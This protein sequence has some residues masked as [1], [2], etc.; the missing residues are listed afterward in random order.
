MAPPAAAG[1]VASDA[2][3]Q[4][5]ASLNSAKG[6]GA[7]PV[8][9]L[10]IVAPQNDL[11]PPGGALAGAI[12]GAVVAR[13]MGEAAPRSAEDV[14]GRINAFRRSASFDLV[15]LSLCQR[16]P[17]SG[18][19]WPEHCIEGT[20]GADVAQGNLRATAQLPPR[21]ERS[22]GEVEVA[23]PS[24][25][26]FAHTRRCFRAV[27]Q[28]LRA[29]CVTHVW[30]CGLAPDGAVAAAALHAAEAGYAARILADC[31]RLCGLA[32]HGHTDARL[33]DPLSIHLVES[34]AAGALLQHSSIDDVR[35]VATKAPEAS[36]LV[37]LLEEAGEGEEAAVGS[38]PHSTLRLAS[39][40]LCRCHTFMSAVSAT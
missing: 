19:R 10:L 25:S 2:K 36:R 28:Q 11:V 31:T 35:A 23:T 3:L 15:L 18:S 27:L 8:H 14:L 21:L 7:A 39:E 17:G 22:G 40:R 20:H 30:L 16:Q 1:V 4:V 33:L 6:G 29:H 26:S 13:E 34:A 38:S 32:M 5:F 12:D 9:A 24:S 37:S